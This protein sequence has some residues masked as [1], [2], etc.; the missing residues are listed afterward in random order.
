MPHDIIKQLQA[1]DIIKYG[2]FTLK[3]GKKSSIYIDLRQIIA[4]P[5]LLADL[6]ELVWKKIANLNPELVCGVPYTALP[7]ATVVSTEHNIPMLIR[8]KEAKDHGTKKLLE[9]IFKPGQNCIII[10]DV[11]TTGMSIFETADVLESEGLKVTDV[12]VC[13]DREE[14]GRQNIEQRGYQLH[15]LMT[16]SE[17]KGAK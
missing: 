14:G 17:L 7:I 11:I 13:I 16:L 15:S 10:E 8:R 2:A 12:I 3:S 6:S 4:Y 5:K 9:G 1:A